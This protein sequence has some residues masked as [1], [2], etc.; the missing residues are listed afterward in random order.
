MGF[1]LASKVEA[2]GVDRH[3]FKFDVTP[4]DLYVP[5]RG[6][7]YVVELYVKADKYQAV[8]DRRSVR[9]DGNKMYFEPVR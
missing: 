2:H 1:N 9:I 6:S 4:D 5:E 3:H 7:V 8:R